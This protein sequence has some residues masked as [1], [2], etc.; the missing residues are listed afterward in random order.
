MFVGMLRLRERWHP[1]ALD[2]GSGSGE[3]GRVAEAFS[4]L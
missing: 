4:A 1:L 2:T 3:P